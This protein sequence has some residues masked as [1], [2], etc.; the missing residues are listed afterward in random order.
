MTLSSLALPSTIGQE[1]RGVGRPCIFSPRETATS[2]SRS[3]E[4]LPAR[5]GPYARRRAYRRRPRFGNGPQRLCIGAAQPTRAPL[6]RLRWYTSPGHN[7]PPPPAWETA[8]VQRHY[9]QALPF[10]CLPGLC[11]TSNY[12]LKIHPARLRETNL[13]ARVARESL[14][15][16]SAAE[17]SC[18]PP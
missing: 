10:C 4:N 6:C 2:R 14:C 1:L 8:G 15:L 11:Q 12:S 13:P 9:L 18:R 5:A 3:A 16:H 7:Q 17:V